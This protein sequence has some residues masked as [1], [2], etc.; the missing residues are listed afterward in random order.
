MFPPSPALSLVD[1]LDGI[2]DLEAYLDAQ[3]ALSQFPTPP[4]RV[5]KNAKGLGR[6]PSTTT[7]VVTPHVRHESNE[8]QRRD[9]QIEAL[10][11]TF[12]FLSLSCLLP[13]ADFQCGN[14]SSHLT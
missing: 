3:P 7:G 1:S 2:E 14:W 9:L 12:S 5:S 11:C 4:I 10:N 6:V 13:S 8:S